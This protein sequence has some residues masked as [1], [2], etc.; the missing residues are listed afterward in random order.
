MHAARLTQLSRL[1]DV[2]GLDAA[3][4]AAQRDGFVLNVVNYTSMAHAHVVARSPKGVF[5]VL[6]EMR[7]AGVAPRNA[8]VRVGI[9]GVTLG[10]LDARAKVRWLL[11]WWQEE[12]AEDGA[13]YAWNMALSALGRRFAQQQPR[14]G[15]WKH[16]KPRQG[17]GPGGKWE[18]PVDEEAEDAWREIMDWYALMREAGGIPDKDGIA[19]VP[20]VE[21][22]TEN[23]VLSLC[24]RRNDIPTALAVFGR[25]C[26]GY[27]AAP[28]LVSY[29]T[30]LAM[31]V[32]DALAELESGPRLVAFVSLLKRRMAR[33]RIRP[34]V[35][36]CTLLLQVITC[37]HRDLT[38][39]IFGADVS[40]AR[41][42]YNRE[43]EVGLAGVKNLVNRKL[44]QLRGMQ[45][46]TDSLR[47]P[48]I[49]ATPIPEDNEDAEVEAVPSAELLLRSSSSKHAGRLIRN[50]WRSL[51]AEKVNDIRFFNTL[52]AAF[53]R[54][55]DTPGAVLALRDM[56]Q[57]CGLDADLYTYNALLSAAGHGGDVKLALRLL[58]TLKKHRSY[59]PDAF[60]YS[61]A[62]AAC[63]SD[64]EESER[65]LDDAVATGICITPP[66]L[67]AA[68][69]C[70]GGEVDRAVRV[71]NSWRSLDTHR[72]AA[73]DMQVYRA[74]LRSAGMAGKPDAALKLLFAGKK[75][76]E[77]EP[78]VTQG[79]YGA[80]MR[81]LR[82]GG[83]VRRVRESVIANQYLRHLQLECRAF[84]RSEN[85]NMSVERVRIRW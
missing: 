74:L 19:R 16:G 27:G 84:D 2:R 69:L 31:L 54:V 61:A 66:I 17:A 10:G 72:E 77:L 55:G 5:S 71:W 80:F 46:E 12:G 30:L 63:R 79:L 75:N 49:A 64:V 13:G 40:R 48:E 1:G 38:P 78:A 60:S 21:T 32:D 59:A 18:A 25:M 83:Q 28:D 23:I 6:E 51:P 53:A 15:E 37:R 73:S 36:M 58:Q 57:K 42:A 67:N 7:A 50:L 39:G 24:R 82:E 41:E 9:R 62:L 34:D 45:D 4:A 43:A 52:I 81:G 14:L 8:T 44:Q 26:A 85:D 22:Y 29:N 33:E 70:Y 20:Q 76:G 56:R 68:L 3:V 47:R 35:I 65:V 11:E